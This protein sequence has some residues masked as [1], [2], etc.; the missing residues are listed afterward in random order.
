MQVQ[1]KKSFTINL[2]Q[3]EFQLLFDGIGNTSETS[4]EKAGMTEAQATFFGTLYEE[5]YEPMNDP[6]V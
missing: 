5:L 4:R 1:V 2:S 3:E 6:E